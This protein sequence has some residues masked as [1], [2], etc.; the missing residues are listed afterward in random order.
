MYTLVT[1]YSFTGRTHYEAKRMAERV[2]GELYEV[3]EQRHRSLYGT[4]IVGPYQARR[5]KYVVVEPFAVNMEDYDRII[6]MCPVWGGYPAPAFNTIVR[7]LPVGR[8]VE[9][10]LTSDSG[11][12]RDLSKLR[13]RVELQ[14]VHVTNISVIKTEDMRKRDKRRRKMMKAEE[15]NG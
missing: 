14:G 4:Y 2:Q 12:A 1:Y 9:I 13:E 10:Y 15:K 6:I 7:E 11:K 3:R 5:R 8:E